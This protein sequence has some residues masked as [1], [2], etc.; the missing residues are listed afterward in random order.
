MG[1]F[2]L[3]LIAQFNQFREILTTTKAGIN[4]NLA[5]RWLGLSGIILT[6]TRVARLEMV[7][8][9]DVGVLTV[10]VVLSHGRCLSDV[11]LRALALAFLTG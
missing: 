7:A 11:R 9:G 2:G 3:D 6:Q 1:R 4:T 8:L 5:S 10:S